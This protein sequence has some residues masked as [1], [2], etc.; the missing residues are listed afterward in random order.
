MPVTGQCPEYTLHHIFTMWSGLAHMMHLHVCSF[1]LIFA[2]PR[3]KRTVWTQVTHE[4][5]PTD[6]DPNRVT[7]D[8][9]G[10]TRRGI[11]LHCFSRG[12][13]GDHAASG[14]SLYCSQMPL[15]LK[16]NEII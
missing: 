15:F 9:T 2:G 1:T 7:A 14:R 5:H 3:H 12:L 8:N 16:I 11:I 10:T 13:F 4:T 6:L